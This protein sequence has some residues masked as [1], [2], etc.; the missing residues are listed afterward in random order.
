MGVISAKKNTDF[1]FLP[2]F[3]GFLHFIDAAPLLRYDLLP[4]DP[5]R[6]F[7]LECKTRKVG[8]MG[9]LGLQINGDERRHTINQ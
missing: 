9:I 3:A 8:T 7:P 1:R 5:A 6:H 2:G 4:P